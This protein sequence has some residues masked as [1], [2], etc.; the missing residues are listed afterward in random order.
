ME[1]IDYST[2]TCCPGEVAMR[3]KVQVRYKHL[4]RRKQTNE[5]GIMIGGQA[6]QDG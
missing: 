5:V 4:L 2:H 1:E 6:R 3:D